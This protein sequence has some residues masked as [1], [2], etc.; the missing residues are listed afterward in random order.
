LTSQDEFKYDDAGRAIKSRRVVTNATGNVQNSDIALSMTEYN[1]IGKVYYTVNDQNDLTKYD[2]DQTG[3]TVCTT[4][5]NI[6]GIAWTN[7]TAI[8]NYISNSANIPY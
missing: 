5:Y 6:S 7:T 8:G 1:S 2:Y 4:T 3:N